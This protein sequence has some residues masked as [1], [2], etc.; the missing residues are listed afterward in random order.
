[1]EYDDIGNIK[2]TYRYNKG[3]GS[4]SGPSYVPPNYELDATYLTE[5]GKP[6]QVR[7]SDGIYVSY[8][9]G[10]GKQYPIAKIV[11]ATNQGIASAL[12]ISIQALLSYNESN[13]SQLNSLRALMPSAQITT[14]TYSPM[15][16]VTSIT[17]PKGVQVEYIYDDFGRLE[18]VKDQDDNILGKNEYRYKN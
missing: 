6:T 14:Y 1:F 15:I 3:G 10:Y 16:G 13:L 7:G 9:W 5:E 11:N 8:L 17:D 12:G 4:H 18:Y 2:N